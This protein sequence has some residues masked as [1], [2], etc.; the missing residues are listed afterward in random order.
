MVVY[1]L[2]GL[3]LGIQEQIDETLVDNTIG[4]EDGMDTLIA[5]L[6]SVYAGDDMTDEWTKY[7]M[8][9]DAKRGNC[10]VYWRLKNGAC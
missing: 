10:Q 4:D 8:F 2:E 9:V 6:N 5:Y 3:V 1:H 7:K